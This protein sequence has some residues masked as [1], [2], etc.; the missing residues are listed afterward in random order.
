MPRLWQ[1]FF[2][3]GGSKRRLRAKCFGSMRP[4]CSAPRIFKEYSASL[5]SRMPV[6]S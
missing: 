6:W 5:E 2:Q 4:D 3:T 1:N